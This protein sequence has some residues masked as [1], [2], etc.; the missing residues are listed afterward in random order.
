MTEVKTAIDE[1]NEKFWNELCGTSLA[2]SLG[3]TDRSAASLRKYDDA[4]LGFYPYLLKHVPVQAMRGKDV[5]EVGLG[6][7]TL[8][9]RIVEAGAKYT[10]AD[11]AAGP[12]ENMNHRIRLLQAPDARAVQANILRS[13]FAPESFDWVVS[14]GCFHH[15]GD[16]QGAVNEA[17][18]VLRPGGKAVIMVYNKYSLRH[19]R[20]WPRAT[21]ASALRALLSGKPAAASEAQRRQYDHRRD[22]E[23]A[24]ETAFFSVGDLKHIFTQFS[25]VQCVKENA[26]PIHLPRP[27]RYEQPR[28]WVLDRTANPI[29]ISR[30]SQLSTVG[31]LAGLDIYVTATK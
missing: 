12:V 14:I 21:A 9:Q 2:Q 11:I 18:R 8:G 17:Y 24:P 31:R 4:Y 23:A 7:G 3:I 29:I 13:G 10:G 22:G 30:E 16:M 5:L 19:W 15:T 6:F 28:K 27:T 20:M 1:A 25:A 26:D